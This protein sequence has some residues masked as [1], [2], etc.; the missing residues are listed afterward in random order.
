MSTVELLSKIGLLR[1]VGRRG[2]CPA[3]K[4]W[5]GGDDAGRAVSPREIAPPALA[6]GVVLV[7]AAIAWIGMIHQSR[8]MGDMAMGDMAMGLGSPGSFAAGWL[9]MMAAMM[10]PTAL[11]LVFEFARHSERRAGWQAATGLLCATYLAVWLAFGV[12]AYLVYDALRMPW[13]DQRLIGGASLV[14]AGIYATTPFKRSSEARCREL[15]AL[16]GPLPFNLQRSAVLVGARYGVSC[17]GCTAALMV[18][19]VLTG[20]SSFG[21]MAVMSGLVLLYKLAPVPSMGQRTVLAVAVAAL[22]VLYAVVG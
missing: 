10:L 19:A 4:G 18:A 21:W 22:G 9:M 11:P 3:C 13:G 6:A 16:H 14:L 2:F 7:V 1:Q 8:S 15:C 20:M 5:L 17:I 12:A